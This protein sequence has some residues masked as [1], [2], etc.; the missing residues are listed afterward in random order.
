MNMRM[1]FLMT[2][3]MRNLIIL[4]KKMKKNILKTIM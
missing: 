3:T 4:M 1:I 2:C